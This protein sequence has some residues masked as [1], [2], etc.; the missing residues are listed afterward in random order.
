MIEKVNVN[1]QLPIL[2]QGGRDEPICYC[3][4]EICRDD[5]VD[6]VSLVAARLGASASTL[7]F[8]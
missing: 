6:W 2:T 1:E 5:C 4:C 3:A 8:I 7:G